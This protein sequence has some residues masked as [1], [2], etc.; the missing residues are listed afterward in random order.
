MAEVLAFLR[1]TAHE[2]NAVQGEDKLSLGLWWLQQVCE[3][4]ELVGEQGAVDGRDC[5]GRHGLGWREWPEV[6]GFKLEEG[7][8]GFLQLLFWQ[9]VFY[10]LE[11]V[12]YIVLIRRF[13][14]IEQLKLLEQHLTARQPFNIPADHFPQLVAIPHHG[15]MLAPLV[16]HLRHGHGLVVEGVV[17]LYPVGDWLGPWV[18]VEQDGVHD[19][20]RQ[21]LGCGLYSGWLLGGFLY[22]ARE[23][24][25]CRGGEAVGKLYCSGLLLW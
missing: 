22:D 19:H 8:F 10:R 23:K 1:L 7:L 4:V 25:D 24:L 16:T 5:V 15:I 18:K 14:V 6:L 2:V 13:P 21:V 9:N 20:Q 17:Q 12:F 11:Q 3:L